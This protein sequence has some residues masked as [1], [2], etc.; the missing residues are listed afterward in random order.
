MPWLPWTAPPPTS[1][2]R[3]LPGR[4]TPSPSTSLTSDAIPT[5]LPEPATVLPPTSSLSSVNWHPGSLVRLSRPL[6]AQCLARMALAF[7]TFNLD[8]EFAFEMLCDLPDVLLERATLTLMYTKC[9]VYP[10]TN[11]LAVLRMTAL[12]QRTSADDL[13]PEQRQ[14][15]RELTA[16]KGREG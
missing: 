7:P 11:W 3:P 5:S 13:T 4:S 10:G 1:S 12:E 9:E 16:S 6:L 15:L 8:P 2:A 14:R